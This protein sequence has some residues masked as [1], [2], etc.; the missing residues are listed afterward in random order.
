V[1]KIIRTA[2]AKQDLDAIWDHIAKDNPEAADRFLQ[3]FQLLAKNP[4]LGEMQPLLA[5]GTYRRFVYRHYVIYYR[6][7]EDSMMLLRILHGALEEK[8]QF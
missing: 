2:K 7:Q 3:R 8:E 5:D 6:T 1:L 4:L